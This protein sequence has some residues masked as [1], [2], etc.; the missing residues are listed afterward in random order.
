[1]VAGILFGLGA[2]LLQSLSYLFSAV[3]SSRFQ[4]GAL[5]QFLINHLSIGL[6]SLLALPLVWDPRALDPAPY[7][8]PLLGAM[9]CYLIAQTALYQALRHSPASRVSPLLGIKVL[10]L[11]LIGVYWLQQSYQWLQWLGVGLCILGALWLSYSGGRIKRAALFWVTLACLGY[12]LSDLFVLSLIERFDGI[13]RLQ[14]AGLSV[15]LCYLLAGVVSLTWWPK[16]NDRQLLLHSLPAALCWFLA[17][18]CLFACFA[19]IGVVF[20]GVVQSARGLLSILL[21]AGLAWWGWRYAEPLPSR[22]VFMQRLA[23]ATLMLAAIAL[24][25]LGVIS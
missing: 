18:I 14:A 13:P 24:F 22:A 20:G 11:A 10:M 15:A 3:F 1:M 16:I 23:A 6:L 17:L 2:A 4:V 12:A 8:L 19:W 9:G 5:H 25:S 21:G 7:G